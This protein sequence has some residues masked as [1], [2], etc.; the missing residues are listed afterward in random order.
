MKGGALRAARRRGAQAQ[1]A[2]AARRR[3][4]QARRA[5]AA[6]RR[7]ADA[8]LRAGSDDG[9]EKRK[10]GGGSPHQSKF[11]RNTKMKTPGPLKF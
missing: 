5:G 1:R 9:S 4:A 7:G 2:G 11:N 8:T 10:V 3:G 6:R